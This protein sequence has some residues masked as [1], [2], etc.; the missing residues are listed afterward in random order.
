MIG[1]IF[2][3]L[4]IKIIKLIN[5][6][7]NFDK[8]KKI[9]LLFLF[10]IL[11]PSSFAQWY[12]NSEYVIT[13]IDISSYADVKMAAPSGY[14]E[15]ATINL[16]FFPKETENQEIVSFATSPDAE[17]ND[18]VASFRWKRPESRIDFRYAAKIKTKNTVNQ[19]REKAKFPVES[20]PDDV[21]VYTKPSDTIDSN[22]EG[23]IRVASELSEGEDD[24]YF[25]VF[26]IA[27]W[28]KNN[29]EYN[30][31]TLTAE[32]SQ[33]A[34]W[35]LQNRQGVCDEMTSLFIAMLRAVGIPARF[36]SGVSYTNSPLFPENWGPH[37]W[38][39]VYFPGYGWVPFD[40]TYGQLG[41][42][43]AAHIKFKDS[44]D[45][46]EASTYYQWLGRNADLDTNKL[47]IKTDLISHEGYAGSPVRLDLSAL[48]KAVGFNSYNLIE[49]A[50]ENTD[51]YYY[52]TE[53]YLIKPKEVKIIDREFKSILLLPKERKKIFWLLKIEGGLDS[54]Y[55]YTFPIVVSTINNITAE[56]RFTSSTKEE[57][58]SFEEVQQAAKLLEEE[59]QKRYSGNVLLECSSD[60]EE[61]YEYESG[62]INC[63]AKN[64]GNIF[65]YDVNVCFEKCYTTNLGIS[66]TKNFSFEI[67]TLKVGEN[68]VP[69]TLSNKVVS[70]SNYVKYIINDEPKIGIEEVMYP[71][72][73]SYGK[74]FTVAFT[75]VKKSRSSP[76]NVI[77]SFAQNDIDKKWHIEE[78]LDNRKFI[79]NI[80]GSQLRYGKNDYKINV[81]YGDG[82]E[83]EYRANKEFVIYLTDASLFQRLVLSLN[84]LEGLSAESIAIM[85]LAGTVAFIG[86][87]LW[88]FKRGRKIS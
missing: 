28:T 43:D 3:I 8:M 81:E 55:S 5:Q 10:F 14:I 82:L 17:I 39:E 48:K 79:L 85:L 35:V 72:N 27:E 19:V 52:A 32:V 36:V 51:D 16:T 80:E 41:W 13:N 75:M 6:Q 11:I 33:K 30:L 46:D 59:R 57:H 23:I 9:M 87:V 49:A 78:L 26:K 25:A 24:L 63:I 45:S 37:G 54:R 67:D 71:A 66:Q 73:A 44:V 38:A 12:Y 88:M 76:K 20:L 86:I 58:V 21:L 42:I 29:I 40:V 53:L 69:V 7:Y 31:S 47:Q 50:V 22:D 61:Y 60:K 18:N 56:A 83:K 68:D 15:T 1:W 77:V 65:L 64:T 62:N 34:S 70:K 74:N 4:R 84:K 2:S